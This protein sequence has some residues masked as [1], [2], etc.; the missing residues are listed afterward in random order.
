VIASRSQ[1]Q[2]VVAPTRRVWLIAFFR[3]RLPF[4]DYV[5]NSLPTASANVQGSN[6][7]GMALID[8]DLYV[9]DGGETMSG[10]HHGYGGR[11][12]VVQ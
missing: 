1:C 12:V 11:V 5:P 10:R 9:T 2:S 7:F 6:P 8:D 4:P 3:P